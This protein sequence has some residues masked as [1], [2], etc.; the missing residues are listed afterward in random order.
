VQP[1]VVRTA[2]RYFGA[3]TAVAARSVIRA[4]AASRSSIAM[5]SRA[6]A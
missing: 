5:R 2:S 3:R 4:R 1:I 6:V